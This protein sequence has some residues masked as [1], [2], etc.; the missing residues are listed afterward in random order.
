MFVGGDPPLT[1]RREKTRSTRRLFIFAGVLGLAAMALLVQ[2]VRLTVLVPARE[3]TDTLVMPQVERGAILDRQG[4]ILAVTTRQRRVSAWVPGLTNAQESSSLLAQ[5]LSMDSAVI[6]DLWNHHDGYVVVKR[7]VTA[8]EAKQIAALK[9][10]G[11]LAGV[12]VEDDFGRF[13]PQGRLASHVVGY[14]GADSVPWDGIEYTFNDD[15]APQP[16]GTDSDTVFGS[17]VFLT[18]DADVEYQVEKIAQAAFET[19]KPDSLSILVMEARSGEILAYSCLPDFDPN[20]FQSDSPHVDKNSLV[21]R[22]VAVS[23]EPGSTF[24]VFSLS[25]M[26]ELGAITSQSRFFTPGFYERR[27]SSGDVIHIGDVGKNGSLT[28]KEIIEYSSNS[29]AAY[30]SDQT[31]NESLYRML[32]RFGFGRPTGLP[33]LGETPG[34]LR[35]PSLWSARSKATV[36]IGQE[37]SVS[38]VQVLQAATAIAN[39]GVLLKPLIVKKIVSPEGKVVREY[40]RE[41]L[42]EVVSPEVASEMLDFME[43][44]TSPAGTARRAAVPGIRISAKT[45]TAQV[46]SATGGYSDTDFIASLLGILP[47][48]DPQLII[49]VVMQNPKGQSYYGSTIAAPIFHDVAV[50]LVDMMGIPREGTRTVKGPSEIAVT[51]PRQVE[52]SSVMPD[53]LGTPKRLLLPLLLR[54]DISVSISGSGFVV[55]QDPQPGTPVQSGIRITLELK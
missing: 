23:Y 13:Y 29:G 48:N 11:K 44:A 4:K 22:P 39:G 42:W 30:A 7:T 53:L 55:K 45:G 26:L 50:A 41:P 52:I 1:D 6:V 49:Y 8:G 46:A 12:R 31:D 27:L 16:V 47:T 28:P 18:I 40:G 24:K 10:Q 15:L 19:N 36:T 33:L 21:N 2:L 51:V 32:T 43:A 38:A 35:K 5:V 34:L 37:I 54:K 20:E 3:G 17:Q 25:S 9:A 14:V